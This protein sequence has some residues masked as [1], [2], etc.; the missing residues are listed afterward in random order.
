MHCFE[1]RTAN[2][3]YFVGQDPLYGLHESNSVTLPPSDSGIG[4]YLAKSWETSI[5]QAL[6]PVTS[7]SS[8]FLYVNDM[9]CIFN[10]VLIVEPEET[11]DSEE[12]ILDMNQIYQIYPDEALGSGQFGVVYGGVHRRTSRP[13]AIKVYF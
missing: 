13:V 12:Q 2:V 5:R 3:D 11:N 4:A 8:E 7:N 9:K 6:L 10:C 1:I